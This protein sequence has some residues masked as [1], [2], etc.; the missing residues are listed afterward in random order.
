MPIV[1]LGPASRLPLLSGV[2]GNACCPAHASACQ[3]GWKEQLEAGCSE[4][5]MPK[6]A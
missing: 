3:G 1:L 5:R 6:L 2:S 4:N